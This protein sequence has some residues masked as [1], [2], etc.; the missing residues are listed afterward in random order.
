MKRFRTI[1]AICLAAIS[2]MVA[3]NVWYLHGLYN[4]IKE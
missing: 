1:T 4:S 2:V 3:G